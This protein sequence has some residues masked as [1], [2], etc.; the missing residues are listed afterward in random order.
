LLT[1]QSELSELNR[2]AGKL[3]TVIEKNMKAIA[4]DDE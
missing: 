2:E 3:T 4:G 1:L